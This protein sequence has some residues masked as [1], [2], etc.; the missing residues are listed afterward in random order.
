MKILFS[1]QANAYS[2]EKKKS[3]TLKNISNS[4]K[5]IKPANEVQGVFEDH[6]NNLFLSHGQSFEWPKNA[7]M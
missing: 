4:T 5:K 1:H 6:T 2:S 3:Q 7:A